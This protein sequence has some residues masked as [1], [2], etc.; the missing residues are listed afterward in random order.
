MDLVWLPNPIEEEYKTEYI[1]RNK[2]TITSKSCIAS[3]V[4]SGIVEIKDCNAEQKSVCN[5]DSKIILTLRGLC[6]ETYLDR[7]YK[8][9]MALGNVTWFGHKMTTIWFNVTGNQF[10]IRYVVTHLNIIIPY[11]DVYITNKN[12]QAT[13]RAKCDW[14]SPCKQQ[15]ND[16]WSE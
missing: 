14:C 12:I 8:P 4:E 16:A 1:W 10:N 7:F 15:Q 2:T 3:Q 13:R 5:V 6:K 9:V 11:L